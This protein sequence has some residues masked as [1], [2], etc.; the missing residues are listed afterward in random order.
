MDDQRLGFPDDDGFVV[1]GS[2][3]PGTR[4]RWC[5]AYDL[6]LSGDEISFSTNMPFRTYGYRVMTDAAEGMRLEVD[7]FP[8]AEEHEGHG[9]RR[10]LVTQIERGPEDD[11]FDRL[12]VTVRG[13][14]G[15]GPAR[16]LAL[17]GAFVLLIFRI[18]PR[19][20]RRRPSGCHH[21][22]AQGASGRAARRS[23]RPGEAVS[24]E[25]GRPEVP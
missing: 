10:L 22:R 7:G 3:P 15:A 4:W 16:W 1:R 21:A 24:H 9:G 18:A 2:V 23:G 20:A 12:R 14:P 6:P 17:G 25:R 8:R 5:G 11:D 13:I 19:D